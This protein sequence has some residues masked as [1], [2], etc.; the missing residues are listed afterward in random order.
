MFK[1][2]LAVLIGGSTAACS[3]SPVHHVFGA[4]VFSLDAPAELSRH[5]SSDK[6][7]L[8]APDD[9]AAVTAAA[10]SKADG[11][12]EESK[13]DGRLEEFCAFRFDSV[14]DFYKSV[15]P[16][17]PI[18]GAG[19]H[20]FIQAFEGVWPGESRPTYYVVA[21]LEAGQVYISLSIVTTKA[22]FEPRRV[23]YTEMLESIRPGR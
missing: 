1:R 15:G 13:A 23:A 4:S 21:C 10:Y 12:L 17:Q 6:F 8:V 7:Q 22:Y 5:T 18:K 11:R 9:A 2:I 20:G 19:S 16:R 14:E 3:A